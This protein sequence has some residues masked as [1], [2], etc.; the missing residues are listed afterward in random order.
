M[1][2]SHNANVT[3]ANNCLSV[4]NTNNPTPCELIFVN[5]MKDSTESTFGPTPSGGMTISGLFARA[6]QPGLTNIYTVEVISTNSANVTTV[7]LSCQIDGGTSAT[8]CSNAGS[9]FVAG[10]VY[11]QI[12]VFGDTTNSP[13]TKWRAIFLY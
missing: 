6:L 7:H 9:S 8:T 1:W 13:D 10:D 12:R 5:F 3:T 11:L 4:N 2:G